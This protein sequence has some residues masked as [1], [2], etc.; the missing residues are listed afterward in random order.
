MSFRI[1]VGIWSTAFL[2]LMVMFDLSFLVR[3]ITRF[4][5]EGFASLISIIFI[6]SA[7]EKILHMEATYGVNKE[8]RNPET[9]LCYCYLPPPTPG[10]TVDF[11]ST[12]NV[13]SAV[14]NMA[15]TTLSSIANM[16]NTTEPYNKWQYNSTFE[17]DY[18]ERKKCYKKGGD[19]IGEGCDYVPDVFLFSVLIFMGTFV[20]SYTLK[21]FRTS[22]FF[23]SKVS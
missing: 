17:I 13:T 8:P 7:I 16:S 5:E 10:P 19:L 2:L 3:Y 21:M 12:S 1:W 20:I 9:E 6:Y 23:P 22:P 18:W 11:N 14:Y 15:T 4:T